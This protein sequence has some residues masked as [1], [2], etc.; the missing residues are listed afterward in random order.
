MTSR[1]TLAVAVS[2]LCAADLCMATEPGRL[3]PA[4][5]SADAQS[6]PFWIS[7]DAATTPSG[8]VN[9]AIFGAGKASF[10]RAHEVRKKV[11]AE[12]VAEVGTL[13]PWYTVAPDRGGRVPSSTWRDALQNA[14][15]IYS[16]TVI[17]ITPGFSNG[18]PA[19]LLTVKIDKVLR[20]L[21]VLIFAFNRPLNGGPYLSVGD[22]RRFSSTITGRDVEMR[23]ETCSVIKVRSCSAERALDREDRSTTFS[24]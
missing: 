14:P 2:L 10:V 11:V 15:A 13:C 18:S 22:A 17:E 9:Y 20:S 6:K 21:G 16:G 24:S 5:L 3:A 23:S 1:F 8:E 7:A 12:A 19:S 4:T